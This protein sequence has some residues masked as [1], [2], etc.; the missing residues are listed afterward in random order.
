VRV[1]DVIR[2]GLINAVRDELKKWDAKECIEVTVDPG[3]M[4]KRLMVHEPEFAAALAVMERHGNNLNS[5]IRN[6]WDGKKLQTLTKNSPQTA[7]DHH[8]SIIGMIT[9]TELRARLTR[10]DMANGF[11]NRNLF[12][13]V[14]R[15]KELP[16]GGSL[17]YSDMADVARRF[18]EAV[19]FARTCGRVRMSADAATLWVA[20]YSELS[21]DKPGLLG[22]VIAR[23]EAQ[24]TRLAVVYALFDKSAIIEPVHLEAALAF[25]SYCEASAVRIFGDSL[26]DPIADE[27]LRALRRAKAGITRTDIWKLFSKHGRSD[28]IASALT[29]LFTFGKARF[30]EKTTGGRPTEVWFAT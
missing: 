6:A 13:L 11:A 19:G 28:Q 4:D 25:W 8:I 27:I 5:V 16:F 12:C 26:G 21:S 22:A 9:E 20:V 2:R 17:E 24:T 1:R 10:T 7:T 14:K 30:E 3:V 18:A 29:S 15:S 23:A